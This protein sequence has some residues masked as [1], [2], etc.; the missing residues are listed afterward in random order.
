MSD[1][2]ANSETSLGKRVTGELREFAI[3]ATYLYVCF[4]ALAFLKASILHDEGIQFAP[5]AFAAIKAV[6]SAKFILVGRALHLGEG[7]RNYPLIVPTLYRSITFVVFVTVL[8]IIEEITVGYLHGRTIMD[9]LSEMGGG[10]RD[11]RIATI[12]VLLLIFI[13]YFAFRSLGDIIGDRVLVRL[14]F[15]RRQ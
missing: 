9:S 12:L 1:A 13:P 8:T 14:Y 10:M 7:F 4:T 2:G 11:Q 6:V 15:E 5:W 3:I